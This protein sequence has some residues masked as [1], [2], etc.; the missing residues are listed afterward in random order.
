[1][2]EHACEFVDEGADERCGATPAQPLA[3]GMTP[4]PAP[5]LSGSSSLVYSYY[6]AEHLPVVQQRMKQK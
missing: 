3:I 4:G 2:E 1:M 6:C 5:G